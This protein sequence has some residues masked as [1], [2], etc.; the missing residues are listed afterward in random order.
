MFTEELLQRVKYILKA[1]ETAQ[2]FSWIQTVKD[3]EMV[4]EWLNT[5]VDAAA[6][7]G[8]IHRSHLYLPYLQISKHT[9]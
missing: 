7:P 3:G 5:S 6:T 8:S 1:L 2:K 4:Q 9:L